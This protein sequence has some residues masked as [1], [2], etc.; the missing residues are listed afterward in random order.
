LGLN[1]DGIKTPI[2]I[3]FKNDKR[4]LG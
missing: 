4:G 3:T 1:S 2:P